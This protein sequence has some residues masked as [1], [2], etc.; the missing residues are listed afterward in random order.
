MIL[1]PEA[2]QGPMLGIFIIG[3]L[4][5]I[6]GAIAGLVLVLWNGL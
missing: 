4:G 3:P 6:A 5:V 1:T 2:N